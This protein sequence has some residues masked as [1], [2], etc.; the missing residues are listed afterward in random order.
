[1]HWMRGLML[2]LV[3]STAHA[4]GA[5]AQGFRWAPHGIAAITEGL[6]AGLLLAFLV[7]ALI[8]P[9]SSAAT[10][11][12]AGHA[13]S[14]EWDRYATYLRLAEEK[15]CLEHLDAEREYRGD[16]DFG[17]T[18]EERIVWKE[19]LDLELQEIDELVTRVC[20]TAADGAGPSTGNRTS[21][22][23]KEVL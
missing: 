5:G 19:L 14:D 21:S 9:T 6:A 4:F 11:G 18:T 23:K 12:P 8:Q 22:A 15:A 13:A 3:F 20:Q 17:K 10:R 2:G 7:K 16:V 1:M